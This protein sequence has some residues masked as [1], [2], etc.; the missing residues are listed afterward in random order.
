MRKFSFPT[1]DGDSCWW[2]VLLPSRSTQTDRRTCTQRIQIPRPPPEFFFLLTCFPRP[3][4]VYF[5]HPDYSCPVHTPCTSLNH[6]AS[7]RPRAYPSLCN[8]SASLVYPALVPT[9]PAN[10][11][12][13]SSSLPVSFVYI[14]TF[15]IQTYSH[16]AAVCQTTSTSPGQY[17]LPHSTC[18]S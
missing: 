5:D 4:S 3:T 9:C 13:C 17:D 18:S 8:H 10:P 1:S 11:S 7:I 2:K 14:S 16:S 12:S 15:F 6:P